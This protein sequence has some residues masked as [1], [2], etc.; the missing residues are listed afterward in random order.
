MP[1]AEPKSHAYSKATIRIIR[2]EYARLRK[3]HGA[4]T[5]VVIV[6]AAR[7]P[8]SPLHRFFDWDDSSAAE[9]YRRSQAG[10]LIRRV[11]VYITKDGLTQPIRVY[12]SVLEN[13]IRQYQEL[14]EVM[15]NK[16][17][18]AEF[19]AALKR[20]LEGVVRR[21]EAYDFCSKSLRLVKIAIQ[22][23]DQ[24]EERKAG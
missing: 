14:T 5:P 24:E 3:T 16:V 18:A 2:S 22:A 23:L 17:T 4:V 21:Y 12:A 10:E 6:D 8:K 11:Q 13:D 9:K 19:M 20:D 1:V 15:A 7:D